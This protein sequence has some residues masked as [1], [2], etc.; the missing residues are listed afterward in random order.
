MADTREARERRER[1]IIDALGTRVHNALRAHLASEAI[2]RMS[3]EDVEAVIG[4]LA[5]GLAED[6]WTIVRA[7]PDTVGVTAGTVRVGDAEYR[8]EEV[9]RESPNNNDITR[10]KR[11]TGIEAA[12]LL[13][14]RPLAG[15][16]PE[17]SPSMVDSLL[18]QQGLL[19]SA[20]AKVCQAAGVMAGDVP[21]SGPELLMLAQDTEEHIGRL[22]RWADGIEALCGRWD[23]VSKGES[24]T[25]KAIRAVG[26]LSLVK[27][28]TEPPSYVDVVFD[29]PPA[30]ESGRFIEVENEQGESVRVGEWIED[31]A[32]PGRQRYW[33]LRIPLW[34]PEHG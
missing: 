15:A 28:A 7:L 1:T 31:D 3:D 33:R 34:G 14:S 30:P 24:G 2:M 22:I 29:G 4:S 32:P 9:F 6:G 13:G 20:L 27:P 17:T 10:V 5:E 25:T 16:E 8:V 12:A 23:A 21:A 26:T 11:I 19:A 18:H